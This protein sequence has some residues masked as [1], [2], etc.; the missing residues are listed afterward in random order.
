MKSERILKIF[1][2]LV[3]FHSMVAGIILIEGT[4]EIFYFFGFTDQIGFF[5][6]QAGVFHLVMGVAYLMTIYTLR[7]ESV[8][9]WFCITAK[10]MATVFL[11]LYFILF[12]P[13]WIVL[14]SGIGDFLMGL[15]MWMFFMN[16]KR[17]QHA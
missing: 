8:I 17:S 2:W 7:K 14:V 12:D 11:V 15:L 13:I 6:V 16:Y 9:I 1:L 10:M 3:T 4:P 5:S